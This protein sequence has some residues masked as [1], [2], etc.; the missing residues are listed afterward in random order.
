MELDVVLPCWNEVA[1]LPWVLGRFGGSLRA[2]VVD[3]NSNDGSG[4]LARSLGATVV[5]CAQQGY[6]A[7]CHAGLLAATADIVA[8]CDCDA[9]LDPRDAPQLAAMLAPAAGAPG[10]DLVIGRR[11]GSQRGAFPVG[12]RIANR[13]LARQVRA[14]TGLTRLRDVG[15]L[16]VAR[17]RDLLDLDVRDRRS[18][19]PVQT[20][21]RAADEGWRIVQAD[22]SYHPRRGSSKVTGTARG[23][24]TAV[25]DARRAL[26]S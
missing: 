14:R 18:G 16:R 17:R 9:T 8:F 23:A 24:L 22:V 11:V 4:E 21:V 1:A 5:E 3:N 2:I 7:A 20:V 25:R 10:A 13:E 19:Y 26:A 15:P 12:A 6:G